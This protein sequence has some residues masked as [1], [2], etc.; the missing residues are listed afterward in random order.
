M[1]DDGASNLLNEDEKEVEDE[2]KYVNVDETEELNENG[3]W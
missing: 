3:G 1:S 2:D